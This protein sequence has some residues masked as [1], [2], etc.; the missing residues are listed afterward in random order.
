MSFNKTDRKLNRQTE[1]TQTVSR[2]ASGLVSISK[3]AKFLSVSPDTLRNWEAQKK[4]VPL[5]S[6]GGARRYPFSQLVSYK[7]LLNPIPKTPI[8]QL[9]V[10][11]A[12]REL[13]VSPDTIR[14]WNKK[15]ILSAER[16]KGGARRFSRTEIKRLQ[17][18]LAI[19]TDQNLSYPTQTSYFPI[20]PA[21]SLPGDRSVLNSN[22]LVQASAINPEDYEAGSLLSVP[23]PKHI[24]LLTK[25]VSF[26]ALG[27]LLLLIGAAILKTS[28][29]NKPNQ[30]LSSALRSIPFLSNVIPMPVPST[31]ST[32]SKPSI[33]SNGSV[34]AESSPSGSFLQINLDTRING[35]ASVSGEL[36]APNIVY[37]IT[38]GTNITVTGD[39]QKP[40]ISSTIT[41]P[42]ATTTVPGIA[43]FSSSFFTVS[44]AGAVSL[45]DGGITTTQIKDGTITN[46]D[47]ASS[48]I[49]I[50]PGSGMSGGGSAS[51]GGSVT[52]TNA[53]VTSIAGT[54]NQVIASGSVGAVTLTLPQDIDVAAD[55][56]FDSLE[57]TTGLLLNGA[58]SG[59][60]T[61]NTATATTS[62]TMTLPGD[63]GTDNYV[64]TTNGSGVTAWEAVGGGAC[65]NCILTDP[66]ATQTITP[67]AAGAI[68][69][70]I[71]QA[72]GGTV[73]IFNV[74]NNA[75]STKYL[76]VDSSGNTTIIGSTINT[77]TFTSSSTVTAQ[78][79]LTQTTGALNL[80]ATSGA[81]TLSG[82]SASS[83]DT[84]INNITF[85]SG[86]FNTTAT[87]INS[88]AIGQ[89]TAAA[90][91]FTT[92]SSTGVTTIGNDSA[93]VA[94]DSSDWNITTTGTISNATYEGLT[95]S[96]TTGTLTIAAGKTLTA[97]N[98]I[99]FT[100]TDGTSFAFPGTSDTVVTLTAIQTLTNKSLT[101]PTITGSPT[102]AGATWTDLGTITTADINGGTIDGTIIGGTS[103]AAGSF[104]TLNASSTVNLASLTAS[105]GVY[106][107]ASK[108]LTSTPPSSGTLG[109]WN[110]T[111]SSLSP[112]NS[113]DAITTSGNISTSGSGT[114]TS[115]STLTAS[116][117]LTLT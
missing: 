97:S 70:S 14:N 54:S 29:T 25:T 86:N 62:Y 77:G 91:S 65:G 6:E 61:L 112:S 18:E 110:R 108:N 13:F 1:K 8:G 84:G 26:A 31:L 96:T 99:T 90:G 116:N 12:A 7:K 22:P 39:P 16:T 76:K 44:T 57:L 55:V 33:L 27:I 98:T 111:G 52:I 49:T 93:T 83:I 46:S 32:P 4:L 69:L 114:I 105:S 3:A 63:D 41:V 85:T 100:G 82:L 103:A 10:S 5:R 30:K 92:L 80:T 72:T 60:L 95:I 17:E 64:L 50:S 102:A 19:K 9:S 78:N 34:L 40:T 37:S 45:T 47:L 24:N 115:A 79:G 71:A 53:G 117:G 38:P 21:I 59:T 28:L 36:T 104:T 43:S 68:G 81:L 56:E 88:T 109:F 75:G 23:T 89:T 48:T 20:T 101:S 2:A 87:G 113:G 73:D 107:D 42:T 66:G 11:K 67:T 15:G 51:L 106:T 58:T 35:T 74:T 94:I